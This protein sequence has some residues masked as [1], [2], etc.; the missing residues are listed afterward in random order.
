MRFS[1][2]MWITGTITRKAKSEAKSSSPLR[3]LQVDFRSLRGLQV[4]L[5]SHQKIKGLELACK[6]R[7]GTW[8]LCLIFLPAN[9]WS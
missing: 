3:S 7:V 1:V 4:I 9:D 6:P 2:C 5:V 8:K